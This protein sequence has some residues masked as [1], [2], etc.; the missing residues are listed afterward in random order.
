MVINFIIEQVTGMKEELEDFKVLN[1][2]S[3]AQS[4]CLDCKKTFS[5]TRIK[6]EHFRKMILLLFLA[7]HSSAYPGTVGVLG[8][9]M[10]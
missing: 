10:A 7:C 6:S 5:Q 2:K 4:L 9:L 8:T 3:E 1:F